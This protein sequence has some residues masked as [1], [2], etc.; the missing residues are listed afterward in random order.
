MLPSLENLQSGFNMI[1]SLTNM[2]TENLQG[3]K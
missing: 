3:D 1:E 2:S